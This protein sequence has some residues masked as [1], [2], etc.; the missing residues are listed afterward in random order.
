MHKTPPECQKFKA[1]HITWT[2]RDK[3]RERLLVLEIPAGILSKQPSTGTGTGDKAGVEDLILDMGLRAK[4]M[5]KDKNEAKAVRVRNTIVG[6]PHWEAKFSDVIFAM[7]AQPVRGAR[8][9][10]RGQTIVNHLHK[11]SIQGLLRATCRPRCHCLW[12]EFIVFHLV[13]CC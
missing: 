11:R 4:R 3:L 12:L 6:T 13:H 7:P 2:A 8:G 9:P 10:R 5:E 1:T